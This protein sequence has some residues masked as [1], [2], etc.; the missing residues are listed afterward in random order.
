MHERAGA[1]ERSGPSCVWGD[2]GVVAA[3]RAPAPHSRLPRGPLAPGGIYACVG[4]LRLLRLLA[5]RRSPPPASLMPNCRLAPAFRLH[6]ASRLTLRSFHI[7]RAKSR[8]WCLASTAE[9][10]PSG[11]G[12]PCL[13]SAHARGVPVFKAA[14]RPTVRWIAVLRLVAFTMMAQVLTPPERIRRAE[15]ERSLGLQRHPGILG[16][17]CGGLAHAGD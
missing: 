7:P 6:V 14:R 3:H 1:R 2:G 8:I 5:R 9:A 15:Q 17:A 4:P 11:Q 16:Y 13:L 10:Y 12:F